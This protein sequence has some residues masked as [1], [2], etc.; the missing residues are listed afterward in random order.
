MFQKLI[1]IG[2]LGSDPELRYT[3]S[4]QPVA[5][6]SLATNRRWVDSSSN[7]NREETAWFRVSV[8]GRQAE[9][10][11]SY[12]E[13]G[14]MVL[15]EGRLVPDPDTG[16]PKMFKRQDGTMGTSY[17]VSASNVRFLSGSQDVSK[18]S[19]HKASVSAPEEAEEIPF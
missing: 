17:E 16:G 11:N 2:N 3:S 5:N 1:L 6:F 14:R 19:T 13:K 9:N 18:P 10:V 7:E 4:G 8:W 12:L 15:V